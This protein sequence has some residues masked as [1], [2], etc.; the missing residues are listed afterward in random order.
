[1]KTTRDEFPARGILAIHEVLTATMALF[2][3]TIVGSSGNY[4]NGS[5]CAEE[6]VKLKEIIVTN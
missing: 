1:M 6:V 3:P 4:L 5:L 2:L